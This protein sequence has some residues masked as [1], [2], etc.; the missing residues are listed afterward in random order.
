MRAFVFP[1]QGSQYVGMS[2]KIPDSSLKKDYFDRASS[3]IGKDLLELCEKGPQEQLTSTDIA[4]P[5]LFVVS[6]L[7]DAFLKDN[8]VKPDV[9]A[10]HS[11]GEYS[12][13]FSAG[14]FSFEDG[15]KLT[16]KRGELMKNASTKSPG[17]MLAV[18]GLDGEKIGELLSKSSESGV[19]VAANF[20]TFDQ[21]V[22]SGDSKAIED[23][24]IIAKQLGARLAKTLDV[25]AAFHSPL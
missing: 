4:Q 1:G 5:A 12:A 11:L 13:L 8:N 21:V 20:N 15:V 10:G 19:I 3:I 14:V 7:Y 18:V 24:A 17:K 25:S 16:S 9:V 22:L 23:A 2:S 6:S